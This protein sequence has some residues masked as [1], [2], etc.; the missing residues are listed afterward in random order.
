MAELTEREKKIIFIKY[1]IHGVSP[2]SEMPLETRVQML[3][4]ALKFTGTKYNEAEM[5]DLGEAILAVQK[6]V[7]DSIMGF[8][9]KNKS[10]VKEALS[11][12]GRGND[13]F[14]I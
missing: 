14:E 2:Y 4:A 13:R 1:I 10:L 7:N 3:Q 5:L 6:S 8:L 9:S 12:M 11:R